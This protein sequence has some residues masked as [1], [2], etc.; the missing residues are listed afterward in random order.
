[1][2]DV[3]ERPDVARPATYDADFYAWS[4]AQ[5]DLVRMRRFSEL[6][7]TN[8]VEEIEDMGNEVRFKLELSYRLLIS[9]LLKHVHQPSHRSR[10][11]LLTITRERANI[12]RV[13]SKNPTLKAKADEIVG[14]MY[15]Y[16]RKEASVE[17]GLPLENFPADCPFTIAQLRDDEFLPD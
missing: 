11:W 13:E 4:F 16:G 6:D 17:T 14:E 2:A 7:L 8:L 3:K 12:E 9:H 1:M 5:A 10:S 15:G